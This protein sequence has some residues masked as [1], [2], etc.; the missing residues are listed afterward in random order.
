MVKFFP[1]KAR[2]I[3][4]VFN[5]CAGSKIKKFATAKAGACNLLFRP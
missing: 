2:N 3:K 4:R 5:G 1:A